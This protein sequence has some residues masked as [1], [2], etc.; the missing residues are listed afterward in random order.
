M[1]KRLVPTPHTQPHNSVLASE[2]LEAAGDRGR[3]RF[4]H[5]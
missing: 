3:G 1:L 5:R 4:E 2:H